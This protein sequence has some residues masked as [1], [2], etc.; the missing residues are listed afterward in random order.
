MKT[1]SPP[2]PPFGPF[3]CAV[4]S[5]LLAAAL[6]I[7]VQAG[8][9]LTMKICFAVFV[10]GMTFS[11]TAIAVSMGWMFVSFGRYKIKP[12]WVGGCALF[13]AIT[14]GLLMWLTYVAS[15]ATTQ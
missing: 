3:I 12:R 9:P 4:I 15:T 14:M 7:A 6:L 10:P 1:D 5:T 8:M 13:I 2:R 11:A